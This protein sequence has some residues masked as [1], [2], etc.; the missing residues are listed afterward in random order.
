M[1]DLVPTPELLCVQLT[2][3]P[4]EICIELP[5]GAR[6]CATSDIDLGDPALI[7]RQFIGQVNTALAPLGPFFDILDVIAQ[8]LECIEAIPDSI[9]PPPDPTAILQCI[10]GLV[11]KVEKLLRLLPPI[12]VLFM[13]KSVLAALIV[14]LEGLKAELESL[15]RALSR[16][17]AAS[18][19]AAELGNFELQF[20]SDC[21]N[22]NFDIQL[23]NL[24][25]SAKPL[26]RL[27]GLVNAL[28]ELAGAPCITIPL[29]TLPADAEA[30]LAIV[31]FAI[32]LLQAAHDAMG[33]P[34]LELESIPSPEEPC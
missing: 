29:G 22:D 16:I 9:G 20:V 14:F 19:R 26:N 8:V 25:E 5:G 33:V 34:S 10:P 21:A 15:A 24:N 3:G 13:I 17:L 32:D 12:P 30:A 2:V 18:L 28:L 23:A 1:A 31:Q 11:E 27:M 6:V 4:G 7:L